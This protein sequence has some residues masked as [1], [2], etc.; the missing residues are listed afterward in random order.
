MNYSKIA[1]RYA[2]ALFLAALEEQKL[3]VLYR[4]L[5]AIQETVE[6]NKDLR[7]FLKTPVL[8]PSEKKNFLTNALKPY[9]DNLTLRFL[10]LITEHRRE[11]L[12][13]DMIRNFIAQYHKYHQIVSASLITP[14]TVDTEFINK[15]K[16]KLELAMSK[17]FDIKIEVQEELIGGFILQ[18]E[19]KEFD[20]SIKTQL[21]KIKTKLETTSMIK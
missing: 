18:I 10:V 6:T 7:F 15:I 5:M 20:A 1:I 13:N 14:V 16:S 3:E 11:N 2:K 4:D 8:N 9:I 12:L 19:D 17:K 21:N